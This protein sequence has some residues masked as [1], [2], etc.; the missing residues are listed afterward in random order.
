MNL[1]AVARR[2]VYEEYALVVAEN[3]EEAKRLAEIDVVE[4]II[5]FDATNE[6]LDILGVDF[7]EELDE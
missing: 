1:Y 2:V 6:V 7:V 3:E 4:D 5:D